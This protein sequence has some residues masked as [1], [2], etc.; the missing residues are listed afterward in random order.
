M[1]TTYLNMSAFLLAVVAQAQVN[2]KMPI[3]GSTDTLLSE[4]PLQISE[5]FSWRIIRMKGV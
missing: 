1:L 2:N 4:P 3:L 5:E